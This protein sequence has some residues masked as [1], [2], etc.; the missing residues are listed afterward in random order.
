MEE[1]GRGLRSR[2][3]P[4]GWGVTDGSRG[5]EREGESLDDDIHFLNEER[6]KKTGL[7]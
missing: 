2:F 4:W 5:G 7:G 1:G 3:A 6:K